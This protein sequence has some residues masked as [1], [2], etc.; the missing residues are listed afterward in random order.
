MFKFQRLSSTLSCRAPRLRSSWTKQIETCSWGSSTSTNRIQFPQR[1]NFATF[2]WDDPSM[3]NIFPVRFNIV[4]RF[5]VQNNS[6][7]QAL[8]DKSTFVHLSKFP[9]NYSENKEEAKKL[10]VL[11]YLQNSVNKECVT[12]TFEELDIKED[13]NTHM[14]HLKKKFFDKARRFCHNF[15]YL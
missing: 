4:S 5:P 7:K 10:G 8:L 3:V 14:L 6:P 15:H 12:I 1:A 2:V 9:K 13:L 11:Q